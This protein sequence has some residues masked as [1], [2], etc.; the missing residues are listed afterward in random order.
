M[1]SGYSLNVSQNTLNFTSA[2]ANGSAIEVI[3]EVSPT[4]T[5]AFSDVQ[6]VNANITSVQSESGKT[7]SAPLSATV[8]LRNNR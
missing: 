7:S 8:R 5:S 6:A 3:Y 4:D 1:T 2:P